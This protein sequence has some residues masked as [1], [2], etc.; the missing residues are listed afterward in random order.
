MDNFTK[1]AFQTSRSLFESEIWLTKPAWRSKVWIYLYWKVNHK[2]SNQFSRWQW[3]FSYEKIYEECNLRAEWV[4][5]DALANFF[6]VLKKWWNLTTQQTTRW[7]IVTIVRYNDYQD[8]N[9]YWNN[10][11]NKVETNPKQTQNKT[12]NKNDK[13]VKNEKNTIQE[14]LEQYLEKWNSKKSIKGKKWLKQCR[15]LNRDIEEVRR[16]V[17]KKYTLEEIN[18]WTRKYMIDIANRNP[19]N[20]YYN[21]RFSLYEFLKQKNA[22]VRFINQ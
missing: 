18:E 21:H 17:R 9:N 12:I 11:T 16:S 19:D 14:E 6:R 3:R 22:L 5:K 10:A 8:L 7:L 20:D 1:W 15:V 13:N 2:D 4:K